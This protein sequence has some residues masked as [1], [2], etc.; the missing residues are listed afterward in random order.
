MGDG[1]LFGGGDDGPRRVNPFGDDDGDQAL[2]PAARLRAAARKTRHLKSQ[3][4]ADGLPAPALRALL[5]ELSV[6]F[7]AMA[8]GLERLEEAGPQA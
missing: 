8:Q 4:G 6:S 7:D 3:V 5:D 2:D 1:N